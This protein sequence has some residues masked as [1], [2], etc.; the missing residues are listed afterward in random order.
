MEIFHN[1]AWGTVC[2]DSWDIN[3]AQVVCQQLHFPG[4]IE[5]PH[6]ATFGQGK[7]ALLAL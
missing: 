5:A 7:E 4:A 6:S 1:G 2:D 3:D